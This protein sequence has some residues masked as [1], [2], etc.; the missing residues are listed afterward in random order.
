[1]KKQIRKQLRRIARQNMAVGIIAAGLLIGNSLNMQA[2]QKA[3]VSGNTSKDVKTEL[4]AEKTFYSFQKP[5]NTMYREELEHWT[6]ALNKETGQGSQAGLKKNTPASY[7]PDFDEKATPG[8]INGDHGSKGDIIVTNTDDAGAG[9]LRQAIIDA[10]TNDG[11][12]NITFNLPTGSE[13][14][15]TTIAGNHSALEIT[16]EVTINGDLGSSSKI[17]V[18]GTGHGNPNLF[19]MRLFN[20]AAGTETVN[21]QNMDIQDGYVDWDGVINDELEGGG[22]LI[23]SGDVNLNNVFIS[24]SHGYHG[25]AIACDKNGD[26]TLESCTITGNDADEHGGGIASEGVL[27]VSNTNIENNTAD[28][29]GGISGVGTIQINNSD[30]NNNLAYNM[31]GALNC[32]AGNWTISACTINENNAEDDGGGIVL[33]G[34]NLE[35]AN[36]TISGNTATDMGG[37]IIILDL[38]GQA[39][40]SFSGTAASTISGNT[41]SSGNGIEVLSFF[42]PYTSLN[43]NNSTLNLQ[44]EINLPLYYGT[45][46]ADVNFDGGTSTVIYGNDGDQAV[47][48]FEFYN[49]EISG[50]GTK[51]ISGGTTVENQLTVNTGA[52]LNV[53]GDGSLDLEDGASLLDIGTFTNSTPV[54]IKKSISENAWH[55]I[56]IPVV[57]QTANLFLNNFLQNW[58]ESTGL[59]TEITEAT[60]AL[61]TKVGYGL[62]AQSGKAQEF[63]FSGTPLTGNQS[64]GI[65]ANG[66]GG[67][68]NGANLLGNPYPSSIDWEEVSGYG[69]VYYWDGS[70]YLAYP[71]GT[72]SYGTGSRY[73]PPMQG[74]FI[75]ADA[76]EN[77]VLT[78]AMRTHEG[79]GSFY[80]NGNEAKL[81]DGLMLAASNGNYEDKL[82]IRLNENAAAGFEKSTDAWKLPSNTPGLSQLW[83]VCNDGNL[84]ID[85]RPQQETIQ[86]GFANDAS[87]IYSIA[88]KEIA[89][90]PEAYLEDTKTGT[91]H[92]LHPDSYPGGA[93]EFTWNPEMD[94]ES[95]FK[96]HFKAVG[97]EENQIS[98]SDIRIYT[99]DDQIFIKNVCDAA[100]QTGHALSLTV[101]D[102]MGRTVLQQAIS[103]SELTAIP[104]N[105]QTGVYI[106]SVKSGNDIKTE[107]V[108]I[109]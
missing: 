70:A 83:S 59:W 101:T 81:N 28:F 92:N 4:R 37:G 100:V 87:G 31:G 34:T 5:Y 42:T 82:L 63:I 14:S 33:Q 52:T 103:A 75:V 108:F 58:N 104:V 73:I 71:E 49:L 26:L 55:L 19:H 80:K 84:S 22:M 21:L 65:S 106:V 10:N 2:N 94:L 3:V 72:G 32:V 96:L 23:S 66:S 17:I 11:H 62:W 86:L 51:T 79:A 78:N 99:A 6:L 97:I 91:F 57:G 61:N 56:S 53:D 30:I 24:N 18:K 15:L 60:T 64:I 76:N 7:V 93:Y 105:L 109:K 44:D 35:L 36:I 89:D 90:I 47:N 67:S 25:G 107:K 16:D 69:A 85:N 68:F 95:R 74:F 9:S 45:Y 20:I 88:I 39:S 54:N 48:D 41:A 38:N 102:M 1:M 77:F 29:G 43:M 13:I 50:S 98:E 46:Q 8:K 40:L 12:D 27:T